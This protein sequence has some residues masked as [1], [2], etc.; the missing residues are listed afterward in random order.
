MM[1]INIEKLLENGMSPE[2]IGNMVQLEAQKRQ[3][4]QEKS[5][6]AGAAKIKEVRDKLCDAYWDYLQ[7]ISPN[8]KMEKE[9][10]VNE[11]S[12]ELIDFEEI[13][14]NPIMKRIFEK[15]DSRCNSKEQTSEPQDFLDAFTRG[16]VNAAS[17]ASACVKSRTKRPQDEYPDVDI[18]KILD[19]F[20]RTLV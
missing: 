10:F 5:K 16:R 6:E 20:V 19:D 18:D 3:E 12:Q 13:L 8:E 15:N 17:P 7:T 4:K 9:Y 14:E 11:M 1:E 2:S